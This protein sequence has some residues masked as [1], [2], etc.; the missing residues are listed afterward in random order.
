MKK[1][2]DFFKNHGTKVICALLVLIYFKTC[3]TDRTIDKVC[4]K[5]PAQGGA[6]KKRK[7]KKNKKAK[8]HKKTHKKRKR[9]S[10][11]KS[12]NKKSKRKNKKTKKNKK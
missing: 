4:I 7:T 6:K 1:F 12:K 11:S 5:A 8:K 10:K 2:N 9:K 3:S